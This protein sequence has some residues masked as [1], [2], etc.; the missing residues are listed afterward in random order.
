MNL[1]AMKSLFAFLSS[2]AL[3]SWTAGA[4]LVTQ[5]NCSGVQADGS[6][7]GLVLHQKPG[8]SKQ[9]EISLEMDFMSSEPTLGKVAAKESFVIE[10]NENEVLFDHVNRGLDFWV[11]DSKGGSSVKKE[12]GEKNLSYQFFLQDPRKGIEK[13][14]VELD[15]QKNSSGSLSELSTAKVYVHRTPAAHAEYLGSFSL[16]CKSK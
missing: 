9:A 11:I 13:F 14:I 12:D 16:E 7:L 10:K 15:A 3:M 1:L 6:K 5:L 2:F 8:T 4:A